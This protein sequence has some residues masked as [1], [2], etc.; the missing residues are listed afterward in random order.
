[1][2]VA[3]LVRIIR[4]VPDIPGED[5]L[6]A[7]QCAHDAFNISFEPRMLARILQ[8]LAA[9]ALYPTGVM[10]SGAR[11]SLLTQL[12][13]RI[14]DRIK[15]DKDWFDLM[16]CRDRKK[17]VEPSLEAF[18]ILLPQQIVQVNPHRIHP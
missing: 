1:M 18:C 3:A 4:L 12:R 14:P 10:H 11:S 16:L 9:G 17:R 15:Q 8:R 7:S 13:I 2:A 5:T 6:I